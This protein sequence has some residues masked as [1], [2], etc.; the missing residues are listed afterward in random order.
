MPSQTPSATTTRTSATCSLLFD[1]AGNAKLAQI[2]DVLPM[3]FAPRN[4]E[5]PDDSVKPRG[6]PIDPGVDSW[7][8]D[9][10]CRVEA[11]PVVSPPF[12]DLWKRY[13]G[14]SHLA[15]RGRSPGYKVPRLWLVPKLLRF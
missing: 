10:V 7:V 9:L 11:D 12:K 5:L 2:S 4:D 15:G 14:A 1:E 13:V 3:I 6:T 8:N